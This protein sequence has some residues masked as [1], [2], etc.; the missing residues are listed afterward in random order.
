[1]NAVLTVVLCPAPELIAMEAAGP[2][3][4]VNEKLAAEAAPGTVAVMTYAPALELAVGRPVVAKPRTSVL[5]VN[6]AVKVAPAPL[7]L[8]SINVT[9]A[10]KTGLPP[11][12]FTKAR[13]TFPKRV[14][15][16]AAWPLPSLT[17]MLAA[18]PAVLVREKGA[19]APTPKIV[20]LT[21]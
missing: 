7:P 2:G 14:P 20:A 17:V 12:S 8:G 19:A 18:C 10:P 3:L 6:E 4:L 16:V 11:E 5:T 13:R 15:T 9:G 21:V 1:M